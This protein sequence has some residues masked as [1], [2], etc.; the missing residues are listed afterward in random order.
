MCC[1]ANRQETGKRP[2]QEGVTEEADL[3]CKVEVI[4][5]MQ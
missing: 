4:G 3:V 5:G 1:S 2:Q